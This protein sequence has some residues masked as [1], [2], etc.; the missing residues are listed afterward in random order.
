MLLLTC[1]PLIGR[2][3]LRCWWTMQPDRP[4]RLTRLPAATT[5][6]TMSVDSPT[7]RALQPGSVEPRL[8]RV[9]QKRDAGVWVHG[10]VLGATFS[11]C[12]QEL[13]ADNSAAF[14][15]GMQ[16]TESCK[17]LSAA[18]AKAQQ[19]VDAEDSSAAAVAS[20]AAAVAAALAVALV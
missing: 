7:G 9:V 18:M 17:V 12:S 8:H 20:T 2:V 13:D 5:P 3:L 14:C 6:R 19:V 4:R 16:K 1:G 15:H 11:P 10:R